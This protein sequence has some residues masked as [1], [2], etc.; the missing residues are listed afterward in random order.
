MKLNKEEI[1]K[2]KAIYTA[3]VTFF[4]QTGRSLNPGFDYAGFKILN[5][6]PEYMPPIFFIGYQPGRDADH[7][8]E[9]CR[10]ESYDT[11]PARNE[12]LEGDW[13]LAN[14]MQEMFG[15][16]L[17]GCVCL[18]AI[19]RRAPTVKDYQLAVNRH[20]R[21]EIKK[22][23]L[24]RVGEIIEVIQPK[25]IVA[26]GFGTLTLFGPSTPDLRNSKNRTLT[27]L[28]RIADRQVIAT[29]HLTGARISTRDRELTRD[30]VLAF[31][32]QS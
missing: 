12:C 10:S 20:S 8:K 25:Q 9:E 27:R 15:A 13:F 32:D 16:K 11:W 24:A 7:W 1:A 31:V 22:F 26:I 2:L 23:C 21:A 6:P 29:L 30:R 4:G 14:R 17:E 28:G 18:N 3:T 19:F 5:T